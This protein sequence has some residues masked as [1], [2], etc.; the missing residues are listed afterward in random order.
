M[1]ATIQ[2]ILNTADMAEGSADALHALGFVLG[3]RYRLLERIGEGGMG[4]VWRGL[5]LD[6]DEVVAI[7]FMREEMAKD[8]R[9]RGYFLREIK[10][11]RRVTHRNVARVF[12]FGHTDGLYYLTM[13]FIAGESLYARLSRSGQ[14]PPMWVLDL[15]SGLCR[16]LAAALAVGV[17]HG[18]IKPANIML[19]PSRGGVITDFGIARALNEPLTG[20]EC[21]SGTPL[22]MAPEQILTGLIMPQSDVYSLGVVLF[23]ALTGRSPWLT[24][25]VGTLLDLK[26]HG[27]EPALGAIAPELP[28]VWLDLLSD[29][30]RA[31]LRHRPR[32]VR[33][34]LLRLAALRGLG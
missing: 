16:G 25:D 34:L 32:D 6:L 14:R 26:A 1:N 21:M 2:R 33:A 11:A 12:E 10:F 3:G 24:C 15:A 17:V 27:H 13:E 28:R 9:L 5:D 29:C 8:Q 7:K 19:A 4:I 22:Y 30:M 20:E 31:E 18:D 23:E